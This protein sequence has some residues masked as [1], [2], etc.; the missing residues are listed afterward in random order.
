M[1]TIVYVD[2][3]NLYY[4]ALRGTP[5]KWLDLPLLFKKILHPRHQIQ[6]VRYFTAKISTQP[7]NLL[8]PRRQEIY[9]RALKV[10]RLNVEVHLGHFLTH[11]VRMP[12]AHPIKKQKMARVIKTEEKGSDVNLASYL[13]TDIWRKVCECAVVVTN[14]SDIAGALDL[15]KQYNEICI[16]L[17]TPAAKRHPSWQLKKHADF[18]K[19]IRA[20]SL[21]RSQL[22]NPIPN[23]TIYKP[24]RW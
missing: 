19:R 12:L 17:I 24:D 22:P 10:Y 18:V 11:E 3:F 23:T 1:R 15:A 4:G 8:K 21:E 9:L 7:D 6:K 2:G 14:D 13:L 20:G 16:G 5:F